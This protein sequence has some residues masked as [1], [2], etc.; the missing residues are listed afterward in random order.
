[1]SLRCIL[2]SSNDGRE[3][4]RRTVRS[5]EVDSDIDAVEGKIADLPFR[6]FLGERFKF[7]NPHLANV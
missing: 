2:T 3:R 4:H 1:M 7:F 6:N 5:L